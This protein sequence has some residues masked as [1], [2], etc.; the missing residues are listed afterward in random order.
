MG[1]FELTQPNA[2]HVCLW[3]SSAL[4]KKIKCNWTRLCKVM[5]SISAPKKR[6]FNLVYLTRVIILDCLEFSDYNLL[7]TCVP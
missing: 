6:P 5:N 7:A 3:E 1:R 2:F 4:Y